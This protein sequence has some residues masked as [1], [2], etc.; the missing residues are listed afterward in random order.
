MTKG[1]GVTIQK[2]PPGQRL[3]DL[4]VFSSEEGLVWHE[5]QKP[6]NAADLALISGKRADQGK[7]A[8]QWMTRKAVTRS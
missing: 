6:R 7:A 4:R 3:V 5:G 2:L 8:P 1:M